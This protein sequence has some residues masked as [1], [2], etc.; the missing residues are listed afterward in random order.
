MAVECFPQTCRKAFDLEFPVADAPKL[1]AG[2]FD[3]ELVRQLV[4]LMRQFDLSEVDLQEGDRRLRLRRGTR[5]PTVA[6]QTSALAS[7]SPAAPPRNGQPVAATPSRLI[8]IKSNMVGN[9]YAKP[10]PD[11]DDYVKVG[12]RVNP[13]TVVCK[14]EAMKIFNDLPAGCSGV[15]AEV[16]VQNG[17]FVEYDQVLFR[18]EPA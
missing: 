12:S 17:T 9:F 14:I 3:V 15:I 4:R 16:C 13:D 5:V 10:A 11:K 6:A 7:A 8:E 2:L 18:V 1:S